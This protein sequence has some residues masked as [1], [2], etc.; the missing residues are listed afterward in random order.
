MQIC[1]ATHPHSHPLPTQQRLCNEGEYYLNILLATRREELLNTDR[2]YD[3]NHPGDPEVAEEDT[4]YIKLTDLLRFA[5]I[6]ALCSTGEE[7]R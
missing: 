2:Y 3:N 7:I 6:S 4:L 1:T 5:K